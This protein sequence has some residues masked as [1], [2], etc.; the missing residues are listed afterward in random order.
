M[1]RLAVYEGIN[2]I[3]GVVW[4]LPIPPRVWPFG[5]RVDRLLRQNSPV[6]GFE[7]RASRQ[8]SPCESDEGQIDSVLHPA[9]T[10]KAPIFMRCQPEVHSLLAGRLF[11]LI[12]Q[13][14]STRACTTS[15]S[16]AARN[17]S[18]D[19]LAWFNIACAAGRMRGRT[20]AS[21]FGDTHGCCGGCFL[22][23]CSQR[24]DHS[25]GDDLGDTDCRRDTRSGRLGRSP[26]PSS[27]IT[28]SSHRVN[29]PASSDA[30]TGGADTRR[31][32]PDCQRHCSRTVPN[33]CRTHSGGDR[34]QSQASGSGETP[35]SPPD[36]ASE[37]QTT[38]RPSGSVDRQTTA[39]QRATRRYPPTIPRSRCGSALPLSASSVR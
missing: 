32:H 20:G 22:R 11:V 30:I 16:T 35:S 21:H 38:R 39:S 25:R 23:A 10:Y 28:A 24:I 27:G 37:C 19:C 15:T 2:G 18:G 1:G 5:S 7:E 12:D 14:R 13:G 4:V 29:W 17:R 36:F 9:L 6:L 34:G 33:Q 8:L 3:R 31:P 26:C